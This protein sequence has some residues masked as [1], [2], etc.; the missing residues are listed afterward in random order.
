MESLLS[1][2]YLEDTCPHCRAIVPVTLHEIR[3][4]QEIEREWQPVR[5]CT[6]CSVPRTRRW[7]AIRANGT[8]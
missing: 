6:S 2:A 3:L 4:E 8:G 1:Y 5:P 7:F